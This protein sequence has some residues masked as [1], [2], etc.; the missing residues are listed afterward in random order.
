MPEAGTLAVSLGRAFAESDFPADPVEVRT[1]HGTAVLHRS[2][3]Q[4]LLFRHGRPHQWLPHRIPVR[5]QM[6]ALREVGVR[7]LVV[8]GFVGVLDD[9]LPLHEPLLVSDVV[10]PTGFLPDGSPATM[11]VDGDGGYLTLDEGLVSRRLA[12]QLRG[13]AIGLGDPLALPECEVHH[14][15]G[16]R[17][18][19]PAETA[20][21]ARQ[22]AR[23]V[24]MT[25][26][27]EIV[28]ANELGIATAA[29][30]VGYRTLFETLTVP[31]AE[32]RLAESRHAL[33]ALCARFLRSG[34]PVASTNR[35]AR[36]G[37]DS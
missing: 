21:L 14:V 6:A 30:V 18:R 3:D 1:P 37:R 4:W 28:L 23:A 7:S 16:P 19:T 27:P 26:V 20:L 13:I 11:F 8:T 9:T 33:E 17:A 15:A 10:M 29:V 34:D 35:L 24:S 36:Y 12:A 5:A 32:R 25:V 31:E 22:G 2:N